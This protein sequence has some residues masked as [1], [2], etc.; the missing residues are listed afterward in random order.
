MR[1]EVWGDES[2]RRL[3]VPLAGYLVEEVNEV[4][5]ILAA[6]LPSVAGR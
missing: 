6:A 1:G 3:W 2:G 5:S 4:A